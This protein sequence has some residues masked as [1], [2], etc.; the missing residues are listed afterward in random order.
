[1]ATYLSLYV[2][3]RGGTTWQSLRTQWGHALATRLPHCARNDMILL[4]NY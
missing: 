4:S 2:S 3:L 1:M